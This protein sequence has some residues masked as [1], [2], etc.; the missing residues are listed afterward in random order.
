MRAARRRSNQMSS[1]R[2]AFW[3]SHPLGLAERREGDGECCRL[4]GHGVVA[5]EREVSG[6]VGSAELVQEQSSSDRQ[7]G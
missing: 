5:E 1:R 6:L 4:G 3:H 2:T 7:I